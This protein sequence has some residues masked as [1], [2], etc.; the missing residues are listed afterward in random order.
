M[1]DYQ[2][3]KDWVQKWKARKDGPVDRTVEIVRLGQ[4]RLCG[5]NNGTQKK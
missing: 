1:S 3:R 5:D 4:Q 2:R